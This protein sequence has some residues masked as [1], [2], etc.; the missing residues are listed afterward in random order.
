MAE[1]QDESLVP[2]DDN[3]AGDYA[4][5]AGLFASVVPVVGG[6][7]QQVLTGWSAERR[8]QRV[9]EALAGLASDLAQFKGRV[10]EEYVRSE[11]FADLLD[12]TLRRVA[13]ERNEE[14]R[15]LY[16]GVLLGAVIAQGQSYD[17]QL[18]FLRI[19]DA[20]QAAHIALLRAIL[21]EPD[22]RFFD[23]MVG[24]PLQTLRRRLPDLSEERITELVTQLNGQHVTSLTSLHTTMTARGAEDLRSA[25]TSLGKR[26]VA[27]LSH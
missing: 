16:R 18:H 14:K 26:L 8:Y 9:R 23:N 1:R 15:R 6:A 24:S 21:Q 20:L 4:E 10:R 27:Y 3:A 19:I 25:L 12:Q 22:P 2:S 7:V 13:T 17:E 11:E 5:L